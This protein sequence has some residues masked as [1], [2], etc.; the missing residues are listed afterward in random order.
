MSALHGKMP[1]NPQGNQ[2]MSWRDAVF[3]CPELSSECVISWDAVSAVATTIGAAGALI[4]MVIAYFGV[5]LPYR[6]S[7][8]DRAA[9]EE[10][11]INE[12][13]NML[14]EFHTHLI[15]NKSSIAI[16]RK[17]IANGLEIGALAKKQGGGC[18]L[19]LTAFPQ[20]P[21]IGRLQAARFS[22]TRLKINAAA[23]NSLIDEF[24]AGTRDLMPVADARELLTKRL[25]FLGQARNALLNE[26]VALIPR[27]EL[28]EPFIEQIEVAVPSPTAEGETP[29]AGTVGEPNQP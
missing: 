23:V 22:L 6:Q 29:V 12:A 16:F 7:I 1:P 19:D 4:T 24:Q 26:M 5:F 25:N 18:K 3:R 9:K 20:L 14:L 8:K 2:G 11:A 27:P 21:S 28:F 15:T 10:D 13:R 17:A